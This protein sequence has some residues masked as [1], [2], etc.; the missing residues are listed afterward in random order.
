MKRKG[1][2]LI[3]LLVVIAIIGLLSTLAVVSLNSARGKARDAQ[4]VSDVKQISTALEIFFASEDTYVACETD[5]VPAVDWGNTDREFSVCEAKDG[6]DIT[7]PSIFTDPSGALACDVDSGVD[8]LCNYTVVTMGADAYEICFTLEDGSGNL[9][10]GLNSVLTGGI[11]AAA[12]DAC[13]G[14][15]A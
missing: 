4:R 15:D 12:V 1:F 5:A 3:E 8:D 7:D 2:T 14:M 9:D 11:F 13:D 10:A 6:F